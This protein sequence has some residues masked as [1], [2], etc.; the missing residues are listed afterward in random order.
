MCFISEVSNIQTEKVQMTKP[1]H[2]AQCDLYRM[3][4]FLDQ[5]VVMCRK[6]C[7][8]FQITQFLHNSCSNC[9]TIIC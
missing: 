6:Q 4:E 7:S 8:A 9:S 3:S 1:Y 2:M 5:G